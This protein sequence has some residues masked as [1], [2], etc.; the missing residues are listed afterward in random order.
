MRV[1]QHQE[2]AEAYTSHGDLALVTRRLWGPDPVARLQAAA[3]LGRLGPPAVE[4]LGGVLR[5]GAD[6]AVRRAAIDSLE[7]IGGR[8]A[9]EELYW[10][11]ADSDPKLRVAAAQAL[12]RIG[13]EAAI[14][15]LTGALRSCFVQGSARRQWWIGIGV[16]VG[17][18]LL[19]AGIV[20][21]SVALQIGGLI[22]AM[23]QFILRPVFRYYRQRRAQSEVCRAITE[24]LA[25]I[26]ERHPNPGLRALIPDLEAVSSDMLQQEGRTRATS[27]AAAARIREL[28][29]SLKSL[30]IAAGPAS[31]DVDSLPRP[32]DA[33]GDGA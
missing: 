33:G 10:G 27:R 30:P 15:R 5:G 8:E 16:L 26:A 13:D 21:G 17:A 3:E 28:T 25:G 18:L 19:F 31:P 22:G 11:L 1:E 12:G 20:A 23:M 4:L 32:A 29:E 2:T 24:A 9:Q 6:T 7:E 14:P